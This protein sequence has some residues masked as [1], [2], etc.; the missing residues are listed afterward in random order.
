M[1]HGLSFFCLS[2]LEKKIAKAIRTV[3]RAAIFGF[4]KTFYRR[5]NTDFF[6]PNRK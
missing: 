1:H 2:Y 3:P 4:G 6:K 5:Q